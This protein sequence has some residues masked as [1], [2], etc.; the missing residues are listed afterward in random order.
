MLSK[1][2]KVYLL[3]LLLFNLLSLSSNNNYIKVIAVLFLI[4]LKKKNHPDA[5]PYSVQSVK[6]LL[7]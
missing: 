2:Q 6:H 1:T 3:F 7:S 4:F 5:F